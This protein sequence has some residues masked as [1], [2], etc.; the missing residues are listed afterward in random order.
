MA[1]MGITSEAGRAEFL[2]DIQDAELKERKNRLKS[3]DNILNKVTKGS[4]KELIYEVNDK[5]IDLKNPLLTEDSKS[6]LDYLFTTSID[7][8][9]RETKNVINMMIEDG[10]MWAIPGGKDGYI[11]F[12]Q[13]FFLKYLT[14]SFN[15]FKVDRPVD[16]IMGLPVSAIFF[17][18][19]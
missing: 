16:I 12:L 13:P 17:I 1:A 15:S 6:E 9:G 14:E 18:N 2:K 5:I 4:Q 8:E 10:L 7:P 19:G 3:L 11:N